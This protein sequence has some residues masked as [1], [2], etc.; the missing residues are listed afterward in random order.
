M[1]ARNMLGYCPISKIRYTTRR[2][3][4]D[5]CEIGVPDTNKVYK[6]SNKLAVFNFFDLGKGESNENSTS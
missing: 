1:C 6:M 4:N 2:S 5:F 3:N